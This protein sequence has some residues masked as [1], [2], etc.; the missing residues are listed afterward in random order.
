M[1]EAESSHKGF[2]SKVV[3]RFKCLIVG[4]PARCRP[5]DVSFKKLMLISGVTEIFR[6]YFV[7]N[8]FDGAL[9]ALGVVLGMW[10]SGV[11]DP[12]TVVR[13]VL[14]AGF[15]MFFS[16]SLGAYLTEKAERERKLRELEESMFQDMR[17]SLFE[18]SSRFAVLLVSL[19]DG[20]SPLLAC[21]LIATPFLVSG[22]LNLSFTFAAS[23]AIGVGI[24]TLGALGVFLGKVSRGSLIGYPLFMILAGLASAI[25]IVLLG[26]QI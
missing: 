20:I 17:G 3:S 6:R 15:A 21:A 16:G 10:I 2:L 23:I 9:A 18:R 8:M 25:V 12:K 26:A 11:I 22:A 14:G 19:V 7:M 4:A 1:E 5:E 24:A 13:T